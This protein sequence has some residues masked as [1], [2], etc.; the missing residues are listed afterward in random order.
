MNAIKKPL[1]SLKAILLSIGRQENKRKLL[2][3]I[4]KLNKSSYLLCAT[5]HTH[6]YL[7]KNGVET[8]LVYKISQ[9][10]KKPNLY[11]LL[12]DNLFDIIV[13]I[14]TRSA[15]KGREHSDGER[16][17]EAA[18]DMGTMLVTDI[19]IAQSLFRKLSEHLKE[20]I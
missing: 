7:K 17:R 14:P 1:D 13:N 9:A 15:K 3:F 18:L 5:Q 16:I 10:G 2:P 8:T 6:D 19:E 20:I 11:E 4:N 12:N